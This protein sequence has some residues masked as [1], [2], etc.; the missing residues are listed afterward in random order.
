MNI[1]ITSP[2]APVTLE[3]ATLMRRM[4]CRVDLCDSLR[5]PLAA[6]L[7]AK[8][9]KVVYHR[10]PAPRFHFEAYAESMQELIKSADLVIPTCEDIFYLAQVPLPESERSKCLMPNTSLLFELHNKYRIFEVLEETDSV[11]FPSTMLITDRA[12]FDESQFDNSIIKPVFS[13]FGETVIRRPTREKL[14]GLTISPEFPWVLQE[15]ID[16]QT[17]CSYALCDHGDVIGQTMY[18]PRHLLNGSAATYFEQT[19][20]KRIG[21]FVDA[22]VRQH[23]VHGQIAFDFIDDGNQLYLLECNP[24]ATSGFHL[25]AENLNFK[26]GKFSVKNNCAVP[27]DH[28]IGYGLFYLFGLKS[29]LKREFSA[30]L[31]DVKQSQSVF[32]KISLSAI[33]LANLEMM[34][35][36]MRKRMSLTAAS[37]YDFEFNGPADRKGDNNP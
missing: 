30:L 12:H 19:S 24:R 9:P 35:V 20:D 31:R 34:I 28:S 22:I 6:S 37:T 7:S 21:K 15:K 32:S 26:D 5:F 8:D 33:C 2:R 23:N 25:L 27:Q 3:W 13:R 29:L 18:K 16:G 1:L 4:G 10:I 36:A 11:K 17:L 14:N